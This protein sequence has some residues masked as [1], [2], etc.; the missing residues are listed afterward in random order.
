MDYN[1]LIE[2]RKLKMDELE[3]IVSTGKQEQRMLNEDE[4]T[5]FN[6]LTNE[7]KDIDKEIEEKRNTNNNKKN[8]TIN[9]KTMENRFSLIKS[10]RDFVETR[11]TSDETLQVMELGKNEMLKAGLSTRGQIILPYETRA[12]VNA[13]TAGEGEYAIAEQKL[14]MIGALRGNLVAVKAGAT[15]LSGLNGNVSIPVY[16]GT[17]SSWKG[18]NITATDGAGA[19]TEVTLAPKRITTILDISKMFLN[20]DTTGAENLLM[21]DLTSSVLA[22]LEA[23]IFSTF[24]GDTSQPAGILNGMSNTYSGVTSFEGIVSLESAINAS[25]ALTGS[26]AYVT[27][28]ALYGKGKTTTKSTYVG[29]FVVEGSTMNGYPIYNT[30]HMATG[31]ILFANWADLLI[32]NW[33]AID[34]TVD[35]Y[36]QAHLG[37]VRLVVNTYWNFAKRRAA[38]FALGTMS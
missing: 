31:K 37:V 12:I 9:T 18:E 13:T 11:S 6:I 30:S 2:T 34:I 35:P 17:T 26:L 10:I 21:S 22:T 14:D 36:T 24:T 38:S 29:G 25:N 5:K 1:N 23:A 15:L 19:F 8:I 4:T 32:G 3:G 28:P 33:G 27:T 16:S 20:Q 7:L